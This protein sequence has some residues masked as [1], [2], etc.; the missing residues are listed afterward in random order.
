MSPPSMSRLYRRCGSRDVSQFYRPPWPVTGRVSPQKTYWKNWTLMILMLWN[1]VRTV[2]TTY[3]Y[4][5]KCKLPLHEFNDNGAQRKNNILFNSSKP[6][7]SMQ[8]SKFQLVKF[9][10][11]IDIIENIL[12]CRPIV[13]ER[14]GKHVSVTRALNNR[15]SL[16]R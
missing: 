16:A 1:T 15:A 4:A 10:T 11:I 6:T 9:F 13:K 7:A 3:I 8:F 5:L 14:V 12:L 2:S